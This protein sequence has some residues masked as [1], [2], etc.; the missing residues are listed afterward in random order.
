MHPCRRAIATSQTTRRTGATSFPMATLTTSGGQTTR[1][2]RAQP[3]ASV[4][5]PGKHDSTCTAAAGEQPAAWHCSTCRRRLNS[6]Q[7]LPPSTLLPPGTLLPPSTDTP[8][9]VARPPGSATP[10]DTATPPAQDVPSIELAPRPPPIPRPPVPRL[11]VP[12]TTSRSFNGSLPPPDTPQASP[13]PD[14]SQA[15]I[16]CRSRLQRAWA[17]LPVRLLLQQRVPHWY[18]DCCRR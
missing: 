10:P 16:P 11:L 8:P 5:S 1:A 4:P 12:P 7:L 13:R 15:T 17:L 6:V 2:A 14:L 3:P 9:T 18:Q